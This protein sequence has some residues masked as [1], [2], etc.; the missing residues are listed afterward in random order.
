M[1]LDSLNDTSSEL[2]Q[3]DVLW[4]P[5]HQIC[6]GLVPRNKY[7]DTIK[8]RCEFITQ[9]SRSDD[10]ICVPSEL[11]YVN[12]EKAFGKLGPLKSREYLPLAGPLGKCLLEGCMHTAQQAAVSDA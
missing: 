7:Q 6:H 1:S 2:V 5:L 8:Q 3:E 4:L 10:T 9:S 12:F 11:A